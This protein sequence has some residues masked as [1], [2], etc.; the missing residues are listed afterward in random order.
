MR[1][2]LSA[3][4]LTGTGAFSGKHSYHDAFLLVSNRS[5]VRGIVDEPSVV[6]AGKPIKSLVV[7]S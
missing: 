5:V 4:K 6:G 2:Y 1:G 3:G 7:D